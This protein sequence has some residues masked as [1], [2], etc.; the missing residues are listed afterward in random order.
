[1]LTGSADQVVRVQEIRFT[2]M[3][4]PESSVAVIVLLKHI[5]A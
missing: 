3:L 2:V 1:M 5:G 4:Q